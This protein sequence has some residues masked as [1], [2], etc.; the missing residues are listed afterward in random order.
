M[1]RGRVIRFRGFAI[2]EFI[3]KNY[4]LITVFLLFVIGIIL[5]VFLF[6][7][8]STLS[9]FAKNYMTDFI[10]SR[11]DVSFW[12][13]LFSSFLNS[14]AQLFL[15]FL[16]GASLFGVVTVPAAIIFK[17]FVQGL[18]TAYLY[19]A[20]AL[21]GVAF[22]AIVYIPI[23]L[24]FII[25]LVVSAKES[26]RFSLKISSLML[27]KTMPL[28]LSFEFKDYCVKFL[29]FCAFTLLSAIIDAVIAAT[30]I[31]NFSF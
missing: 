30:L 11:T 9:D 17:G 3:K 4:F 25:I 20:F 12:G 31:T 29:S 24:V 19:S 27:S 7:K 1:P 14:L 28:N 16:L 21:K 8:N 15:L 5:G 10:H 18:A 2:G 26:I 13:I 23:T 6:E 22:N